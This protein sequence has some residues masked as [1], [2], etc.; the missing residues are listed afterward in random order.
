L[1]LLLQE[2]VE[3]GV[4][5]GVLDRTRLTFLC[6]GAMDISD[7]IFICVRDVDTRAVIL[8]WFLVPR[9]E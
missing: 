5:L 2:L 3:R 7:G 8:R 4:G 9:S 1:N 6:Q